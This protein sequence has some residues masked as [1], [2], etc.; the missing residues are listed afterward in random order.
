MKHYLV[1]FLCIAFLG[2]CSSPKKDMQVQVFVQDLKKGTLFLEREQDSLLVVVDSIQINKEKP[3]VLEADLQHPELFYLLLD[4]NK[5]DDV[6]N[7]I[8]FFGEAGNLSIQTNLDDYVTNAEIVG[9]STQ[10][11]FNSYNKVINRFNNEELDLIAAYLQAQIR[12][13]NDSL[14][15]IDKQSTNLI[16]RKI[17]FTANFAVNNSNSVIAPYLALYKLTSDSRS[18][19]D[20]IAA[21]MTDDVRNSSY[22]R[23]LTDYLMESEQE[24]DPR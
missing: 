21:S 18:L 10:D 22:G 9:S 23:E 14:A 12:K 19:L 20:T 24:N 6:D 2:S 16:K 15:L 11:L 4:R 7:R 3:I 13:N 8:P 1:K 17:L 5:A